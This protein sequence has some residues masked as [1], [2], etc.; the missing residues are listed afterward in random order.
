MEC[1]SAKPRWWQ[2]EG[3]VI[4]GL[5]VLAHTIGR[6]WFNDSQ[7]H[8]KNICYKKGNKEDKN[9]KGDQSLL[10]SEVHHELS[11]TVWSSWLEVDAAKMLTCEYTFDQ[12]S[13]GWG[14][15]VVFK[16]ESLLW[17][18]VRSNLCNL[19]NQTLITRVVAGVCKA[20]S[21]KCQKFLH[22]SCSECARCKCHSP[23]FYFFSQE[24]RHISILVTH[25]ND[26]WKQSKCPYASRCCPEGWECYRSPHSSGI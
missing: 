4:T 22:L 3:S 8:S 19:C 23:V 18:S 6:S 25:R 11:H 17:N 10:F 1:F 24:Q 13:G 21:S 15:E 26:V 14:S 7:T 20:L 2:E 12:K 16:P 9:G 5:W